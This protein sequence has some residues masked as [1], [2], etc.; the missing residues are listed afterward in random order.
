[1]NPVL[2]AAL[3]TWEWRPSVLAVTFLAAA[4][5]AVG[6]VGL[7]RQGRIR[8]AAWWRLAA[9]LL[10]LALLLAALLSFIDVYGALLLFMHMVQHV[11]LLMLVPVLLLWANPFPILLYGLPDVAR[12]AVVRFLR[13]EARF[14][15]ETRRLTH[16]GALYALYIGAI[17]LWHDTS[18]YNLAQGN[19]LI[20]DL[21]HITF[22]VAG[23]LFWWPVMGAAPRIHH[24]TSLAGRMAVLLLCVPPHVVVGALLSFVENPVYEHYLT[25]PRLWGM[26]VMQDQRLA[27]IIM[28]IPTGMMYIAG[29]VILLARHLNQAARRIGSGLDQNGVE[30]T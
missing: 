21:E 18:L 27:G 13:P 26:D 7:R 16:P 10:G 9:Y 15:R 8:L 28:W 19:G 23:M 1:M 20:H 30:A 29:V 3:A 24:P 5:Y 4:I 25:V 2:Q 6:W 22:F 12:R 17:V 11:L 14:R